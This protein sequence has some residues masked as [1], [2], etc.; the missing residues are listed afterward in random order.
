MRKLK[1]YTLPFYKKN[2]CVRNIDG[3]MILFCRINK[4]TVLTI[5][6]CKINKE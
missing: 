6:Y 3:D 2:F 5:Q 4:K 1:V